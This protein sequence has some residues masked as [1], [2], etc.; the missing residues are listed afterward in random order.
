MVSGKW[1]E[2]EEMDSCHVRKGG[3]LE[4]TSHSGPPPPSLKTDRS[5]GSEKYHQLSIGAPS[6]GP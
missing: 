1:Q 4:K 2:S 3:L 5:G 6:A